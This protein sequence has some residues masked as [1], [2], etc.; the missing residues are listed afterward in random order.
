MITAAELRIGNVLKEGEVISIKDKSLACRR[1]TG[2]TFG[3][4][5]RHANPIKLT[6]E[7]LEKCGFEFYHIG[8][9]DF[10]LVGGFTGAK[11]IIIN[12]YKDGIFGFDY[13]E[14]GNVTELIYLH[15]L[16]NLYFALTGEELTIN[17]L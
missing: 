11:G 4:E 17:L 16:Q 1:E 10:G 12:Q 13:G 2:Q 9:N 3:F 15:Q 8:H 7:L 6:P 14:E 5:I